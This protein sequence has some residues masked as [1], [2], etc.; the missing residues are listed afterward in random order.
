MKN[1][2]LFT[3]LFL[4]LVIRARSQD[5]VTTQFFNAPLAV[6][7]TFAA[8]GTADFQ[9][10]SNFR[11]QWFGSS[12]S[13]NTAI[14][15]FYGSLLSVERRSAGNLGIGG[16]FMTDQSLQGAYKTAYASL[17]LAYLL[18]LDDAGKSRLGVGLA[19]IYGNRRIDFSQLTFISQFSSRGF[20]T[21]LPTGENALANMSKYFSVG[22]GILFTHH[23]DGY[24]IKVGAGGYHFNTPRQTLVSDVYEQIPTRYTAHGSV[25][26]ELNSQVSINLCAIYQSQAT[27]SFFSGGAIFGYKPAGE[28]GSLSIDIGTFY[29][30]TKT[31]SPY[32]GLKFNKLNA[33][34]SY[35]LN[36]DNTGLGLNSMRAWELG[37]RFGVGGD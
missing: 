12:A 13:Y 37:V 10:F 32:L 8:E 29:R 35:D 15:S 33:G 4:I 14:T 20:N 2:L 16:M 19:G 25:T 7:P 36:L 26:T 21:A 31:L 22:A 30:N 6:N 27:N 9:V 28:E 23:L 1:N 18:S 24:L 5:P 11:Q 3:F 34:L 17:D